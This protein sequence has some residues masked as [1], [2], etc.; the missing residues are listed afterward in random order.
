M[1]GNRGKMQSAEC[2]VKNYHAILLVRVGLCQYVNI[3]YVLYV[4]LFP[5]LLVLMDTL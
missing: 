1:C 4:N 5:V 2:G 3:L